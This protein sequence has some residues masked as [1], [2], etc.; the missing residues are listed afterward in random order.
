M[1]EREPHWSQDWVGGIAAMPAYVTGEGEPYRPE[2]LLWLDKGD[3]LLVV[4]SHLG[5]PG[6]MLGRACD[7][8]GTTMKEPMVGPP[9]AP[10]RLR[11]ASPEL[12]DVLRAGHPSI[13]IV[14]GPTPE[15]DEVVD[16]MD[17]A[18][19][20]QLGAD[21]SFL[22]AD[23]DPDMVASFFRAAAALYRAKPWDVLP[24]DEVVQVTVPSHGLESGALTV[25]GHLGESFGFLL[26]PSMADFSA[27]IAAAES[28]HGGQKPAW[29]SY[30][31]LNY[32]HGAD[33]APD[34]RKEVSAHR[35]ELAG[36]RAYPFAVAMDKD[37]V[38]RP[39]TARELA[40][41]EAVAVGLVELVQ[42][43]A[44]VAAAFAGGEPC[45]RDLA[46]ATHAGQ[47]AVSFRAPHPEAP[48]ER[49]DEP[50]VLD[51]LFELEERGELHDHELRQPV[52]DKLAAQLMASPEG[53]K[54]SALGGHR[55]LMEYAASYVGASIATLEPWALNE[56]LF[57]IIPR[58]VSVE[59]S[60]AG[61]IVEDCRALYR[62]LDRVYGLEQAE[63][64][65]R[66]LGPGA[67]RKL[68]KALDDPRNFGMA[69]SLF[70]SGKD[71]GFDMQSK[72]GI[73]EWMR[74]IQG[75]PLPPSVRLPMDGVVTARSGR[76]D[77][78]KKQR[79]AARKARK[80]NR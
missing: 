20:E 2:M 69:K 61:A 63:A 43:R 57:D 22:A 5:K 10:T 27:Y 21:Q 28:M 65:L 11:V 79:K 53:A 12:A 4:G 32:M 56:V 18:M 68:A 13:D 76:H 35:W 67:E 42:E 47:V 16:A 48:A 23:V 15:I 70:M 38:S 59:A 29:P 80:R 39:L 25:M 66:A 41:M 7:S 64:C 8:L 72:E 24:P 78:R 62:F 26:F 6:D 14:C 40:L 34:A 52:E 71:A 73:E 1:V 37:A 49:S 54:V 44:S 30:L 60:E 3:G 19:G 36:S 46:V 55:M 9:R 33:L 51:E 74:S 45:R 75:K 77:D 50:D 58:K 17:D 31:V